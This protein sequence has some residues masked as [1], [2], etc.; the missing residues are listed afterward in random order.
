MHLLEQKQDLIDLVD[1]E[2]KQSVENGLIDRQ[3]LRLVELTELEEGSVTKID[4]CCLKAERF[5]S[6]EGRTESQNRRSF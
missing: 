2:R 4:T 6:F 5:L 3:L 1:V